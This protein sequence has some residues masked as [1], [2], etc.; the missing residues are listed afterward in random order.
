LCIF[1]KNWRAGR[2]HSGADRQETEG[3]YAVIRD[4]AGAAAAKPQ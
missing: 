1:L 2:A 3:R 4:R